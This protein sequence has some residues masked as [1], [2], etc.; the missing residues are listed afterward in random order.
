MPIKD[1]SSF[2]ECANGLDALCQRL[3]DIET[4]RVLPDDDTR[5]VAL[6][7]CD[8]HA[9]SVA[10]VQRI[11]SVFSDGHL[12]VKLFQQMARVPDHHLEMNVKSLD[13]FTRLGFLTL[14]QFQ[15]ETMLRDLLAVM[16][17]SKK[18]S[19]FYSIAKQ[20]LELSGVSDPDRKLRILNL[21]ALLR[22]SLH[23]NGIHN[24]PSNYKAPVTVDIGGVVY[25]FTDQDRVT[26]GG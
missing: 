25:Q 26:C 14:Y 23:T 11:L 12:P 16:S 19:A 18:E 15:L 10:M 4:S 21:P 5:I 6:R 3:R 24:P 7:N 22:N 13:D 9:S 17:P 8:A 20:V 1:F 2:E